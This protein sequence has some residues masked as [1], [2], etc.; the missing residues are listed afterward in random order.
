MAN[1]SAAIKKAQDQ[2]AALESTKQGLMSKLPPAGNLFTKAIREMFLEEIATIDKKL[3]A[4]KDELIEATNASDLVDASVLE[5]PKPKVSDLLPIGNNPIQDVL[6]EA[7]KQEEEEEG[8]GTKILDTLKDVVGDKVG[9]LIDDKIKDGDL[10]D[11]AKDIFDDALDGNKDGKLGGKVKDRL[12]ELLGDKVEDLIDDQIKDEDI[13]DAIKDVAGD[14]IEGESKEKLGKRLKDR[15]KE[16]L[17]KKAGDLI[18]DK[19]KDGDIADALKDII[20]DTMDGNADG[21]LGG[22]VT[23]RLKELLGD[24]V[25]DLIDDQIKDTDIA[26]ALKDVVA[27]VIEG[28]SKEELGKRLKDRLKE[29]LGDKAGDLIDD[30]IKD[31]DIADA[32]KDIIGDVMDGNADGQLGGKVTDRLKDLLGDKVEDLIDGNVKD[33]DIAAALKDVVADVIEGE[34]KEELGKRLK[35]RLKELLG[36]KAGDLIDDKIKDGDIADALK[37]IIGDVMDGNADGQLGSKIADRFK[38]LLGE[39]VEDLIDGNVKDADLAAALKG[40]FDDV[41]EGESKADLGKRLKERLK[42]LLGAKVGDLIDSKIPDDRIADILKE[43]FGDL[44]DG[45]FDGAINTIKDG[46]VEIAKEETDKIVEGLVA[47]AKVYLLE[48]IQIIVK[49]EYV[50]KLISQA[51]DDVRKK[52]GNVPVGQFVANVTERITKASVEII[53]KEVVKYVESG[54]LEKTLKA[55]KDVIIDE[56]A[57]SL[58]GLRFDGIDFSAIGKK[59]GRAVLETTEFKKVLTHIKGQ[60]LL[61]FIAIIEDEVEQAIGGTIDLYLKQYANWNGTLLDTGKRSVNIGPFWG[62]IN[63]VLSI[64]AKMD[65]KLVSTRK[66]LTVTATGDVQASADVGVGISVGLTLPAIGGIAIE[67]GI[68]GGPRIKATASISLG[69]KNAV[70][71]GTMN[72]LRMDID[73]TAKLYLELPSAVPE[74]MIEFAASYVASVTSSGHTLYYELG[75]LNIFTATTPSYALSFDIVKGKYRYLGATGKYNMTINPKVKQYIN[76]LKQGV[77]H[78]GNQIEETISDWFGSD[79]IPFNGK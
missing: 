8:G 35:D 28:E 20:G 5:E 51:F 67:G 62:C 30:K 37:D 78:A 40:V 53:R 18:D 29:L 4:A 36:D 16:L 47:K 2:I 17:G 38:D 31:G 13:A 21:H 7:L 49:E 39:K 45:D 19:I 1:K 41:I 69:V 3:K 57:A 33:T 76:E 74:W 26:D 15:L 10:A 32:L 64:Q 54:G 50:D 58:Q 79:W 34:S 61:S 66:E 24:K 12:K 52:I 60:V 77:E 22:K 65:A 73:M 63:I 27:D 23:D 9:D 70:L 48:K 59:M 42:D 68:I 6:E 43:A 44:L 72:P 75:R 46:V 55:V 14:V 25:E 56:L 11:T 71:Q